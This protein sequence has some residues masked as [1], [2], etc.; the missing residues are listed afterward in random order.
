VNRWLTPEQAADLM[1]A[2]VQTVRGWIRDG[3]MPGLKA[4][5]RTIRVPADFVQRFRESLT[6]QQA[7]DLMTV[8]AKTVL[9]WMHR[10]GLPYLWLGRRTVRI[11]PDDLGEWMQR[12]QSATVDNPWRRWLS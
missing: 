4:G 7:S 2:N 6:V 9:Q 8:S 3:M 12:G 5:H 11:H 1:N 10:R